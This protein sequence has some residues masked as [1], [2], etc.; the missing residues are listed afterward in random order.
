[1]T[2]A[3]KVFAHTAMFT[4]AVVVGVVPRSHV[5]TS[6]TIERDIYTIISGGSGHCR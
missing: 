5:S 3:C 4:R 1:M 2:A 6:K